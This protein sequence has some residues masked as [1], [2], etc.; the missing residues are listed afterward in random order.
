MNIYIYVYR[1]LLH[2][3]HQLLVLCQCL[4]QLHDERKVVVLPPNVFDLPMNK[5]DHMV[6][7]DHAL[8]H[9]TGPYAITEVAET[10]LISFKFLIFLFNEELVLCDLWLDG[11]EKS[12]ALVGVHRFIL[13]EGWTEISP[14]RNR[15]FFTARPHKCL[16]EGSQAENRPPLTCVSW[17]WSSAIFLS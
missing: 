1:Y 9:P 13:E 7:E 14:F 12:A 11:A 8:C 2:Q 3:G 17:V 6:R 10:N 4:Q 15:P 5:S 16:A